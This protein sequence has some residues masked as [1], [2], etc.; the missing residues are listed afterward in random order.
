M[1]GPEETAHFW[2]KPSERKGPCVVLNFQSEV[3]ITNPE[4]CVNLQQST[5][6]VR[7]RAP[8]VSLGIPALFGLAGKGKGCAGY[9]LMSLR[10]RRANKET[11]E[12]SS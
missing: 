7:N 9:D 2:C 4:S 5:A 6:Q 12:A 1:E 8:S 10:K 3:K 11:A